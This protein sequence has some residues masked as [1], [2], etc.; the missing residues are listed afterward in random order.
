VRFPATLR[1][2]DAVNRRYMTT[3]AE[4][5]QTRTVDAGIEF[6]ETNVGADRWL[7]QIELFDPHEPF[8]VHQKYRELYP[9][10]YEGPEFDWPDYA[11][12]SEPPDQVEHVRY[13]YA[14]LLT[15]C[16]HYL[17]QVLDL[18][19]APARGEHE[20]RVAVRAVGARGHDD[21]RLE[22]GAAVA[23]DVDEADGVRRLCGGGEPE[24]ATGDQSRGDGAHGGRAQGLAMGSHGSLLTRVSAK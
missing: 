15:M 4:H 3:E 18:G 19:Q 1:T 10:T 9:D 14:A 6:L 7:L 2:Q 5:T 11:P 16:D 8:F 24:G 23:G 12:V 21:V 17:G 22:D 20:Q 13:E